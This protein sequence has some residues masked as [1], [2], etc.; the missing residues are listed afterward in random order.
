MTYYACKSRYAHKTCG[1]KNERQFEI[2]NDFFAD[3][4]AYISKAENIDRASKM[5]ADYHANT[6]TTQK[7]LEYEKRIA[8]IDKEIEK[9]IDLALTSN[10]LMLA[11]INQRATDFEI[12]RNDLQTELNKLRFLQSI[13]KTKADYV[14]YL[15]AFVG[16]DLNDKQYRKRIINGLINSIWLFDGGIFVFYNTDTDKQITLDELKETLKKHDIDY[17]ALCSCRVS[18][19][20]CFGDL[21]GI[22][23][24]GLHRDRVAF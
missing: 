7:T 15:K 6:I 8:N 11:K 23:T 9:L 12:Q 1:K 19:R 22:R 2:E 4:I 5:L 13:P 3:T 18:N 17:H 21:E 24:L 14:K 10:G 20:E 16:G